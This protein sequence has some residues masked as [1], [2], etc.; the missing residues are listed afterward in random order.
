MKQLRQIAA[1]VAVIVAAFAATGAAQTRNVTFVTNAYDLKVQQF[2][3]GTLANGTRYAS[4]GG[5][6]RAVNNKAAAD[7]KTFAFTV[8]Y[9]VDA[10]GIVT[11]TG[12]TFLIQTTNKDRS[13][14]TVGGDILQGA[15]LNIRANGSI[16][17]G[18]KL[19]L[20]LVGSEGTAITGMI[21]ASTDKSTQPK[22]AGTLTLTYPVV[23]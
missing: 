3:T 18:Q 6:A 17:A 5:E 9:D 23:Q 22:L 19:S 12:G 21:N 11:V 8:F 16:D 20:A 7:L 15:T 1:V 4:F 14:L 2:S 10:S 13:T